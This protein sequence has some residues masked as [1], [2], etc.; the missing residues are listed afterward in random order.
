MDIKFILNMEYSKCLILLGS[1]W[2]ENFQAFYLEEVLYSFSLAYAN[3][4]TTTLVC[5]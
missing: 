4:S 3:T 2:T 1:C 5:C